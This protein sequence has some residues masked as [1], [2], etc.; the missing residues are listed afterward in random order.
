MEERLA[1]V[2]GLPVEVDERAR[3]VEE[4]MREAEVVQGHQE[5]GLATAAACP[6]SDPR[7]NHRCR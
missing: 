2:L 7:L 3:Q 4:R 1:R 6:V 5:I